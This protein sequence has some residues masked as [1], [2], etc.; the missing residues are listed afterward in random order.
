MHCIHNA[1]DERRDR[2]KNMIN[3]IKNEANNRKERRKKI[4][5]DD[6]Q[7]STQNT[8][9]FELGSLASRHMYICLKTNAHPHMHSIYA[10]TTDARTLTNSQ[11]KR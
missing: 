11:K 1:I 8:L 4:T 5:I 9:T 7:N 2:K 10:H 6:I 3:N